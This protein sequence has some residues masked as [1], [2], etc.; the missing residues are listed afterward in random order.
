M[1]EKILFLVFP[2]NFDFKSKM[3]L[4]NKIIYLIEVLD[5]DCSHDHS[6]LCTGSADKTIMYTD[7]KTAKIIRKYRAHIGNKTKIQLNKLVKPRFVHRI[8]YYK[9]NGF[10]THHLL[11]RVL[12]KGGTLS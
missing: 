2:T 6:F 3:N 7:V 10:S 12:D 4:F 5:A 1:L 11:M 9:K 8:L